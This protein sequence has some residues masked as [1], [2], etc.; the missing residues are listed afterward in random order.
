MPDTIVPPDPFQRA[1]RGHA[2]LV[3]GLPLAGRDAAEA[4]FVGEIRRSVRR[5]AGGID[6]ARIEREH[7]IAPELLAAAAE[8]GLFGLTIP[9]EYGGSGL[10]LQGSCGVIEELAEFDR[11]VATSIGL[12][13]GLGLRGL[14]RYG[15]EHLKRRYLPDMAAGRSLAAFAA[16]E[17]GAG[18]DL[19]AIRAQALPDPADPSRLIL[20][21]EKIYITN[22]RYARLFTLVLYTPGLGG[23]KKGHSLALVPADTPGFTI[24][25]EED[26]LGLRG[27]STATI[28]CQDSPLP[29]DHLI[30]EPGKGITLMNRV[31]AWGRTLMAAG[32]LGGATRAL[33]LATAHVATRRQFNR[34]LGEFE[35]V[36][37]QLGQMRARLYLAGSLVRAAAR[38]CDQLEEHAAWET[39]AAKILASE[40]AFTVIDTAL[41]LHGGS[42]FIE[43]TGVARALRDC[44]VTRIFEGANDVL[45]LH[46]AGEALT[47]P[48]ADIAA[49]PPL[50]TLVAPTLRDAA[51]QNDGHLGE[52]LAA[53]GAARQ[54]HGLKIIERQATLARLGAMALSTY[55]AR[56]ALLRT[57]GV[58]RMAG[59]EAPERDLALAACQDAHEA[60]VAAR[61]GLADNA[62]GVLDRVAR[63]EL[64]GVA[65]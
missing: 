6:S 45:R 43:E 24:G 12:H 15:G 4:D 53:I 65:G 22:A 32:C 40:H 29:A 41:Q 31:L 56:A 57:E 54:A 55:A 10:T 48:L 17:A 61:A 34:T 20:N 28:H 16:T 5:F 9:E 7:V 25:R 11:S 27:S 63:R 13:N 49:L 50:A 2:D 37:A 51:A 14:I 30:G 60:F 42:G 26:K 58:L 38:L 35:L 18:S 62:D 59:G 36:R 33:A 47:W 44:R 19:A 46:L 39:A 3:A 23:K 52:L 21:G 8:L 64:A 1:H